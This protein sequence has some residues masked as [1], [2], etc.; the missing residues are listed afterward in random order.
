M[1]RRRSFYDSFGP[2]QLYTI[3]TSL[4]IWVSATAVQRVIID[5]FLTTGSGARWLYILTAIMET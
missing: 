2:T 1:S 4:H 3:L 5:L